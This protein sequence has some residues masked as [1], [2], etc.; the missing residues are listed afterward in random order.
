MK[1]RY[2]PPCTP[3]HLIISTSSTSPLI[4]IISSDVFVLLACDGVYDFMGNQEIVDL[5]ARSL[6]YTGE[7]NTSQK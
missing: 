3:S 7:C 1:H 6:G 2:P 5:L 4:L